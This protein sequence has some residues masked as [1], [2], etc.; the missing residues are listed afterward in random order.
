M[1]KKISYHQKRLGQIFLRDPLVVECIL[2]SAALAP[3]DTVLEIGPGR[4]IL[5]AA[6]AQRTHALYAIEIDTHYA[7]TLQQRFAS[8]THVH[9]IEADARFYD[10]G[11][12]PPPMVVVANLPYSMGMAILQRLLMFHQRLSRLVI[13]LQKEV[14]ARLLALPN[15]SA[16]GALSV[17]FQYY[18]RIMHN[19]DVSRHAFTPIP[20]VDSSVITLRPFPVLPWPECNESWL[21][22]MV[23]TAFA[24][25]RKM[26]RANLL[27]AFPHTLTRTALADVFTNLALNEY[28]RAQELSVPQFVQLAQALQNLRGVEEETTSH[29]MRVLD[30]E[31]L[32]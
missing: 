32:P 28:A 14:A 5:T 22:R 15:S 9:I 26:L 18:A 6:L 27:A 12:L 16:Y 25:R 23:K 3:G 20:T 2:Q 30:S 11:L 13:M 8:A 10:Y 17:F 29:D 1:P 4:G 24:H 7:R 31:L 19:F 21:F